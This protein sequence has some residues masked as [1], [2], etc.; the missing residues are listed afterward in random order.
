MVLVTLEVVQQG[1]EV[2][3]ILAE[4]PETLENL[5]VLRLW[6]DIVVVQPIPSLLLVLIPT[7]I[8]F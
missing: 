5:V 4:A 6:V 1:R 3:V 8:Q 2:L 7:L